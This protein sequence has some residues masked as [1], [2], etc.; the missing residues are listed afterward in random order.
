MLKRNGANTFSSDFN[1]SKMRN[2]SLITAA[3]KF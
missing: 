1:K 3:S 2:N